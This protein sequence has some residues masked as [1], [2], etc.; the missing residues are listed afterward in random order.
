MK[1]YFLF[2]LH[3]HYGLIRDIAPYSRSQTGKAS[4]IR[5]AIGS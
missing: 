4:T 2:M 3:F 5:N 1:V